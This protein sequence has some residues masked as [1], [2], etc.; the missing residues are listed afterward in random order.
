MAEAGH[1]T[2]LEWH[3]QLLQTPFKPKEDKDDATKV[4]K[5]SNW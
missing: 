2:G 3:E 5:E 4:N 1:D